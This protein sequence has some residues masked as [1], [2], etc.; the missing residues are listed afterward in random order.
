MASSFP[1]AIDNFVNPSSTTMLDGEGNSDLD[2]ANQHATANDAIR[3]VQT[4]IGV[5][6]SSNPA[7]IQYRLKNHSHASISTETWEISEVS[8]SLVFKKNG[9]VVAKLD[10]AGSLSVAGDIAASETV[11]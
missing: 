2:H 3:A 6:D 10:S 4:V 11:F 7:S 9:A 5:V 1:L 8:G